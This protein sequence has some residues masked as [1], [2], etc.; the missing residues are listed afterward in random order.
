MARQR[1]L[2]P[3]Q[4]KQKSSGGD[5]LQFSVAG[6]GLFFNYRFPSPIFRK[7][8]SCSLHYSF[9][10]CPCHPQLLPG[11]ACSESFLFLMT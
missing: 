3:L 10:L 4:A 6:V 8:A 2:M 11:I 1:N 9:P 5:R 7:V